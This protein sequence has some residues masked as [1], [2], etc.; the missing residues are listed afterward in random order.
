MNRVDGNCKIN[1]LIKFVKKATKFCLTTLWLD[2]IEKG[3]Q[4]EKIRGLPSNQ[5]SSSS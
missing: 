4:F 5:M 2:W 1:I 3:S